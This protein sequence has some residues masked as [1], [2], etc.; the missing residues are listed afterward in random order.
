MVSTSSARCASVYAANS[1]ACQGSSALISAPVR[2]LLSICLPPGS[3]C[4][5]HHAVGRAGA[6]RPLELPDDRGEELLAVELVGHRVDGEVET[7]EGRQ[8]HRDLDQL[9]A[10]PGPLAEDCLG[11][12]ADPR[13][14]H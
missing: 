11:L 13:G 8:E 1:A 9:P 12:V 2:A 10:E 5:L 6:D 14:D 3:V 4:A 7:R